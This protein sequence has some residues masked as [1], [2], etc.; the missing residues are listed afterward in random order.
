VV[1]SLTMQSQMLWHHVVILKFERYSAMSTTYVNPRQNRECVWT[2]MLGTGNPSRVE[3]PPSTAMHAHHPLTVCAC[4]LFAKQGGQS[5][6]VGTCAAC[7]AF[8]LTGHPLFGNA[9]THVGRQDGSAGAFLGVHLLEVV[10][11]VTS[12]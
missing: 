9:R 1:L 3:P 6:R 2:C 5:C 4:H 8:R 7:V 12:P 10:I 11:D